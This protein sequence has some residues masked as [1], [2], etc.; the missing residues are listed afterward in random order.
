MCIIDKSFKKYQHVERLGTSATDNLLSGDVYVFP[1]ID[2]CNCCVWIEDGVIQ[3][4]SRNRQLTLEDDNCGFYKHVSNDRRF[5]KFFNDHPNMRLY[6]EWLV[7]NVIKSYHEDAWRKFYVFDMVDINL[8]NDNILP[9]AKYSKYLDYFTVLNRYGIEVIPVIDKLVNPTVDDIYDLI[10]KN[11]YLLPNHIVGEGLVVKRYDFV[12]RFGNTVWGK[13]I[14]KDFRNKKPNQQNANLMV[15]E[16]IVSKYLTKSLVLKEHAK[17]ATECLSNKNLIPR[18]LETVFK[19]L[20][21]E[22]GY[23][24]VKK[25]KY[26][27]IDFKLLKKLCV[28]QIKSYLPELFR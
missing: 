13:I 4:G 21:D 3:A 6:G 11:H 8:D 17:L 26:P 1:K 12:N 10:D 23:N 27:S 16:E 20:I 19:T 2:G 14:A 9:C 25:L 18:L 5:I 15:E 24:F 28:E 22:E 7:P